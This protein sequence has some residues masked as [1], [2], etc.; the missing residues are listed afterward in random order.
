[1]RW[2]GFAFAP[3]AAA[4]AAIAACV[5]LACLCVSPAAAHHRADPAEVSAGGVDIPNLTHGQIEVVAGH[6]AAILDLARAQVRTDATFRRI[7]NFAALQRSYCLWGLVPGSLTDEGSPFNPCTH[8]YL[9]ALNLLLRH[10]QDM[11]DRPAAARALRESIEDEMA[12]REAMFAVCRHGSEAF[13][14]AN[15]ITPRWRDIATHPPSLL[16]F[17]GLAGMMMV[18]ASALMLPRRREPRSST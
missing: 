6:A 15:V 16:T 8:A 18:G 17:A 14:T 11:P 4:Q 1:M 9:A 7:A 12:Q 13:N 3:G 10:M 5:G 2:A